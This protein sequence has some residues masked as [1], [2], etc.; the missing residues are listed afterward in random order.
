MYTRVKREYGATLK[1]LVF[2]SRRV[3]AEEESVGESEILRVLGE[4]EAEGRRRNDGS[5]VWLVPLPIFAQ[6]LPLSFF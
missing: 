6:C 4:R 2:Y 1:S 3:H 5:P